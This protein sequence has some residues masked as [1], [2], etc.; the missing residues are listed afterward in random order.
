VILVKRD[1]I[2]TGARYLVEQL[3][4]S[5]QDDIAESIVSDAKD[6]I[7]MLQRVGDIK[8]SVAQ[9]IVDLYLNKMTYAE[10]CEIVGEEVDSIKRI[11]KALEECVGEA[12][13]A[14]V[15]DNSDDL[16]DYREFVN[17]YIERHYV[18]LEQLLLF[19]IDT[20]D[21]ECEAAIEYVRS[22]VPHYEVTRRCKECDDS[23]FG[24][25]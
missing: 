22:F 3:R 21:F 12:V 20:E 6:Y 7:A 14:A 11:V 10:I 18:P 23:I 25:E 9:H 2:L 19:D 16:Q 13:V 24:G 5:G 15:M 8:D 4:V 1:S 17:Q